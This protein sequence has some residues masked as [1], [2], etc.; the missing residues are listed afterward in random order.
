MGESCEVSGEEYTCKTECKRNFWASL[1]KLKASP[2][3]SKTKTLREAGRLRSNLENNLGSPEWNVG[4]LNG[5]VEGPDMICW[6]YVRMVQFR[7]EDTDTGLS[8][9]FFGGR[10]GWAS[11]WFKRGWWERI[12]RMDRGRSTRIQSIAKCFIMSQPVLLT[13]FTSRSQFSRRG[14]RWRGNLRVLF[15]FFRSLLENM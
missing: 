4:S 15:F 3:S 7:R 12:W 6:S 11:G 5:N 10:T 2:I 14:S 9:I 1:W 8:T 13:F